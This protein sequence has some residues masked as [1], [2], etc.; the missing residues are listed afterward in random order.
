MMHPADMPP[1]SSLVAFRAAAERRSFRDAAVDLRITPSAVSHQI[2]KLE[3]WVGGPLF[4]RRVRQVRL[5]PLGEDLAIGLERGFGEIS[6]ALG[7][8]RA[9]NKMTM[10]RVSALPLFAHGW[11]V[12]RLPAFEKRHPRLSLAIDTSATLADLLLGEADVAIRNL[13]APTPGV[14]ASKLLD[15]RATPLCTPELAERITTPEDLCDHTL[16]GLSVGRRGWSD[17]F[18]AVGAAPPDGTR[19]LLFDS[20]ATAIDASA[21]GRGVLL[22]LTPLVLDMPGARGLVAPLPT[23]P[24]EAGSYFVV[25]RKEDRDNAI[26]GDFV[27]WLIREMHRDLPRLRA[28]GEAKVAQ[29]G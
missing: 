4:E 14:W 24:Q 19:M 6:A 7:R 27:D 25:C 11:L 22:A 9:G 8:A 21:A 23:A 3:A 29:A 15:I 28:V 18:A 26:I 17:W 1:W 13:Q 10:L 5:T 12:Q 16:I 20:M 2:R